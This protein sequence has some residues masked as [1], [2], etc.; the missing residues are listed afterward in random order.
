MVQIFSL[1]FITFISFSVQANE[2]FQLGLFNDDIVGVDIVE[3]D[4][5]YPDPFI[6]N[7]I[8]EM[9]SDT[10]LSFGNKTELDQVIKVADKIVAFG[11]K[12]YKIIDAGRPVTEIS[13]SEQIKVLPKEV[14]VEGSFYEMSGWE[15]PRSKSFEVR[16]KNLLGSH[17]V[18]FGFT[19]VFQYGGQYQGVGSYLTGVTI[20]PTLV[21]V[22]WG[23]RLDASYSLFSIA[24]EGSQDN[25]VAQA[26]IKLN[27]HVGTI[28]RDHS[29]ELSFYLNGDG[30]LKGL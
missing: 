13:M 8:R 30:V 7:V 28:L 2:N 6:N 10:N 29:S 20:V 26:I 18:I 22:D 24:N 4:Q 15:A 5:S 3:V 9:E 21:Q 27:Y 1:V 11:K 25:P 23:Y 16:F 17:P 19:L 12:I 14:G